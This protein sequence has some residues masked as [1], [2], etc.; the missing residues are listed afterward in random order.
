MAA[1][2][3]RRFG[4][5]K[6]CLRAARGGA[7]VSVVVRGVVPA[8]FAEFVVGEE[9]AEQSDARGRGRAVGGR[10]REEDAD[11]VVAVGG[12]GESE[13]AAVG[14]CGACD[15][16][17]L[18]Q[19]DVGFG[20]GEAVG[21]ARLD[22]D[23]AEG[24]AL[25]GDEVDLGVDEG[26]AAVATDVE[27][28][29]GGDREVAFAPEAFGGEQFAASPEVEV[30]RERGGFGRGACETSEASPDGFRERRVDERVEGVA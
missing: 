20:G 18:A 10:G 19:I 16:A 29:V 12:G 23:E 11:H 14:A 6:V 25:V 24:A 9:V 2:K 1:A 4:K 30:W 3:R 17:L 28:E 13:Q 8:A 21:G 5:G 27:F 22:L 7:E 15:L 26:A